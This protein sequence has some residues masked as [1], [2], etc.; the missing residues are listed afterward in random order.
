MTS[1]SDPVPDGAEGVVRQ[2]LR[3]LRKK[4]RRKPYQP[5][6]AIKVLQIVYLV[7]K[8]GLIVAQAVAHGPWT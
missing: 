7:T 1:P 8:I 6:D 5:F 3:A 4:S 2:R